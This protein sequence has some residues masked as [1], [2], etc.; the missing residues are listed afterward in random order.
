MA[1][2]KDTD[3]NV[4]TISVQH[5]AKNGIFLAES[6]VQS[7]KNNEYVVD[8]IKPKPKE[9]VHETHKEFSKYQQPRKAMIEIPLHV[10]QAKEI[11]RLAA[12]KPLANMKTVQSAQKDIQTTIKNLEK[13]YT[14]YGATANEIA[15]K[16]TESSMQQQ[17][18]E[19]ADQH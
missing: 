15:K 1:Y 18:D 16:Y 5:P 7:I 11:L 6:G 19:P 12:F 13:Q 9:T 10:Q 4:Q 17:K 3:I 8:G 2:V 14:Y